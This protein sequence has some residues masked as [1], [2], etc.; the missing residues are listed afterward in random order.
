FQCCTVS[1]VLLA[2]PASL[3]WLEAAEA[4][5][6]FPLLRRYIGVFARV[7]FDIC[8]KPVLVEKSRFVGSCGIVGIVHELPGSLPNGPLIAQTPLQKIVRACG[9]GRANYRDQ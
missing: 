8:E 1:N 2:H 9:V 7:R 4:I 6:D 3:R 5:E